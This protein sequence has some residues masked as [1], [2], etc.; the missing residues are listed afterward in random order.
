MLNEW[1]FLNDKFLGLENTLLTE[2]K[3]NFKI[4]VRNLDVYGFFDEAYVGYKKYLLKENMEQIK[5]HKR[6]SRK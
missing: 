3:E 4:H 6:R 5:E 2:D 1:N